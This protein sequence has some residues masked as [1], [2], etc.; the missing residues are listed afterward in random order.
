MGG[1]L[2][3]RR[4]LGER[5]RVDRTA[6]LPYLI[7]SHLQRREEVNTAGLPTAPAKCGPD[8]GFMDDAG[9][10]SDCALRIWW[11]HAS[12][13]A[14]E[15]A[16]EE[17]WWLQRER[18]TARLPLRVLLPNVAMAQIVEGVDGQLGAP[19]AVHLSTRVGPHRSSLLVS[20][21]VGPRP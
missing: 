17:G 8:G 9:V 7:I 16:A 18:H 13:L 15:E 10:A 21:R 11:G 19:L 2:A 1:Q 4:A 6:R 12:L 5:G 14:L 3:K 20:V